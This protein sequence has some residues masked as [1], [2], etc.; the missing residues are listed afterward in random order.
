MM[1]G[2]ATHRVKTSETVLKQ[3]STTTQN[4]YL[5]VDIR[6]FKEYLLYPVMAQVMVHVMV[7]MVIVMGKVHRKPT[8]RT[9]RFIL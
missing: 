8:R 3:K 4:D 5:F 1:F 6:D 2:L 7:L 9:G